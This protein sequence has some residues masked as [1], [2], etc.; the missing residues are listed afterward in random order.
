MQLLVYMQT[1]LAEPV[2]VYF[3]RAATFRIKELQPEI[4]G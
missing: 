1:A 2:I 3:S 4:C